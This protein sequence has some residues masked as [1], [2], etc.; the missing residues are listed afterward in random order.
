MV[1]APTILQCDLFSR[2]G[3]EFQGIRPDLQKI[4]KA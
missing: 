1:L 3:A 4:G 2:N